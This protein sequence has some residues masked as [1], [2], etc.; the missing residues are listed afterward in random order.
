VKLEE[1]VERANR[2]DRAALERLV[3]AIQDDVYGIA[4]RMLWHPEDALDA[5][6]EILTRV[7]THLSEF[8]GESAFRTWVYRVACN[9]LLSFRRSRLES[10]GLSFESFGA[11]LEEGLEDPVPPVE[12]VILLEEVKIG[13]T[14]ALLSCLDREHRLAY[15]LGE[16][17]ELDGPEAA[18]ALEI[19][20]EAY[21]KRLSRGRSQVLEFTRG[22]CGLVNPERPC[23]CRKRVPR[24]VALGRV[25]PARPLFA[26]DRARAGG[27]SGV[28]AEIR[29]L[30]EARRAAALYRSHPEPRSPTDFAQAMRAL[31]E[32]T[33]PP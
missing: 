2:G 27:F 9:A 21:R 19:S 5:T 12:D 4:L 23:R 29:K 28:V 16:I 31:V 33:L 17:L 26:H 7:V 18:A 30:E 13:C 3:R 6:Q 1:Q 25:D 11:D 20:P 32:K 8:R 22:H 24:A 14:L 10:Q 15:V